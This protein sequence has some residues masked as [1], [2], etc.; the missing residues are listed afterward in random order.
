MRQQLQAEGR[1]AA[2]AWV[3]TLR[4]AA[5]RFDAAQ[6]GLQQGLAIGA[7]A[8]YTAGRL[9][10]TASATAHNVG[11]YYAR[12]YM[13]ESNL[14]YMWSMPALNGEGLRAYATLRY[15][16]SS[17]LTLAAKYALQWQF[18][19]E[20]IGSGDAQTQCP[21]RQTWSLQLRLKT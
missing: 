17:H 5:C 6:S 18:G 14:Q 19:A 20:S 2:G 13:N 11:G 15:E 4:G 21:L 8:R 7:T 9:Q 10:A 3:L 12:I 1:Y 16:L